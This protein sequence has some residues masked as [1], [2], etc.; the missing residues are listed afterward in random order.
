MLARREHIVS[1]QSSFK[2]SDEGC[3]LDAKLRSRFGSPR[4]LPTCDRLRR[5]KR[6]TEPLI[7]SSCP[8][9]DSEPIK[10][11]SYGIRH[12]HWHSTPRICSRN[13]VQSENLGKPL[14]QLRSERCQP[15]APTTFQIFSKRDQ[16]PTRKRPV[17]RSY[18]INRSPSKL[19]N[20]SLPTRSA[21]EWASEDQPK[22]CRVE[23]VWKAPP[24]SSWVR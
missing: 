13:N 15:A 12:T 17:V 5:C 11:A 21:S 22:R 24:R 19:R 14:A 7:R 1:R 2:S 3:L 20:P 4:S 23:L 8:G 18:A 6:Q 16:T 9:F 10:Q